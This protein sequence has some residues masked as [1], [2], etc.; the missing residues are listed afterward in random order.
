[1]QGLA[2]PREYAG[3]RR[4]GHAPQGFTRSRLG[5]RLA[6]MAEA[7]LLKIRGRALRELEGWRADFVGALAD[8]G[9]AAEIVD[10]AKERLDAMLGSIP[11]PGWAAPHMRAFTMGG[12]IYVAMYLALAARGYDA[13][14]AWAVCEAAT[15]AH[16]AR[17][18]GMEKRLASDGL[19]G[20][21]MKALSR[22]LARRSAE[23]PVGGWVFDFVEG[24]K[25]TFEYGVDYK[26]C[27]IRELAIASG[28]AD[29]APYICLADVS[30]SET[31]GWGLARSET[32]AQGGSRCDFR[33]QRGA[34]TRIKVRLPVAP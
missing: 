18:S 1:M 28:A 16:F 26:R 10:D 31:F 21:P 8:R 9:D 14:A 25:G 29:F 15:R 17:M 23:A 32:L 27:A 19:F 33:F 5:L 34:E 30:G 3:I 22:W 13:A 11:D 4:T 2:S 20:W 6:A 24:E 7:T 12:A